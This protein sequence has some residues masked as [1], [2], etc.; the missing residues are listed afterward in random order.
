VSVPEAPVIDHHARAH[1]V[2]R[3]RG[4]HA[5]GLIAL[6]AA[7]LA[8]C[9]AGSAPPDTDGGVGAGGKP[10]STYDAGCTTPGV[11]PYGSVGCVFYAID[12]NP[13][14]LTHAQSPDIHP[15]Y[16]VAVSNAD[17]MAS[18]HVVIERKDGD[19]W[20]TVNGGEFDVLPLSLVTR[21]L[22]HRYVAGSTI[23]AGGAYRITSDRPVS[24]Y[25]FCPLNSSTTQFSDASLLL[26]ASAYDLYYILPA[27]PYGPA[28][29]HDGSDYNNHAHLQIVAREPTTVTVSSPVLTEAGPSVPAIAAAGSGTFDLSEG[30][31]LQ[32]TVEE[33]MD[34]L[35]G[36]YIEADRPVAVF[37]SNDCVNVPVGGFAT[38]S[39]DHLEEQ[40]FGLQTWG[41]TYVA[42]RVPQRASEGAIWQIMARDDDTHVTLDGSPL[43]TGL[44]PS[45]TLG[46]REMAELE[47][48]GPPSQPGDFVAR[49]DKPI[50]VTQYIVGG[51]YGNPGIELGD[52][53]MILAVP[54][55]QYL[56]EYVVLVPKTWAYDYFVLVRTEGSVVTL[57]GTDVDDG[58]THVGH[59]KFEVARIPVTD[60]VHELA[61]SLPL[62]VIV[63]G[64]DSADSYGYPGGLDQQRISPIR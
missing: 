63:V 61:A 33:W 18:A 31:F 29:A 9:A 4:A 11:E 52:P 43:V 27:W 30:D 51:G 36:A 39:C 62:G 25:Q 1:G 45:L 14:Y 24:A 40:V 32:L 3:S 35:N 53:S 34:S 12:T 21:A 54:V 55:E 49:A 58:W 13:I 15:T 28:D 38:R 59:S 19:H 10:A 64:Y 16:A 47:V 44:P 7:H 17:R 60:G 23:Y 20:M 42:A 57:D 8:A 41:T 26:P 22:G 5:R 46:A 48:S 50:L 2:S 56:G 37:S 6:F